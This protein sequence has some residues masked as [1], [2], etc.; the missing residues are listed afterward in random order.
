MDKI[1]FVGAYMLAFIV[2][3]PVE[4]LPSTGKRNALIQEEKERGKER[5]KENLIKF[6][7]LLKLTQFER[8]LGNVIPQ[9]LLRRVSVTG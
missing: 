5:K 7:K 9:V 6:R 3:I 8:V 1:I 4:A 2:Y